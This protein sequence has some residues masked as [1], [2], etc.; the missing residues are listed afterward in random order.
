MGKKETVICLDCGTKFASKAARADHEKH[1]PVRQS[2]ET[3]RMQEQFEWSHARIER[4]IHESYL[5]AARAF[6]AYHNGQMEHARR[7]H[8]WLEQ[9][10]SSTVQEL[11]RLN[12]GAM[13]ASKAPFPRISKLR[14][15]VALSL[16]QVQELS[17]ILATL[18]RDYGA[19]P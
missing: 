15:D 4:R 7:L 17:F 11:E 19:V 13:P 3:R 5:S 16:E 14:S 8:G 10:F 18:N 9:D 12:D 1:C 6:A 2:V